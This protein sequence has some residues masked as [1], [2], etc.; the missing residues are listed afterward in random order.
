MAGSN[1]LNPDLKFLDK[2]LLAN[3]N[4][5][6]KHNMAILP[7]WARPGVKSKTYTVSTQKKRL[8]NGAGPQP[9]NL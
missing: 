9:H 2:K 1:I 3:S 7:C 6:C 5:F 8:N 4:V